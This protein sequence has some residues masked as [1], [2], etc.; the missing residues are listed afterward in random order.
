MMSRMLW[1]ASLIVRRGNRLEAMKIR[2]MVLQL[3]LL[4]G[5]LLHIAHPLVV[6]VAITI[7]VT[8]AHLA[9]QYAVAS[10]V[11]L[12]QVLLEPV[13]AAQLRVLEGMVVE[14]IWVGIWA[15]GREVGVGSH[16]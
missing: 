8:R 3:L 5:I 12:W 7:V 1:L 15:L 6:I 10:I 14:R 16:M 2:M 11:Q 9:L 13:V 4:A